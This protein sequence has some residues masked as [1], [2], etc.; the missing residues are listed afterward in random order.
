MKIN[1][2]N[3]TNLLSDFLEEKKYNFII[4]DNKRKELLYKSIYNIGISCIE[5][6]MENA[7][8]NVSNRLGW[9]L[10][11]SINNNDAPT[12]THCCKDAKYKGYQDKILEILI[13]EDYIRIKTAIELRTKENNMWDKLFDGQTQSLTQK[14]LKELNRRNITKNKL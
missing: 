11:E 7:L 14:F 10:I 6:N 5:N 4:S 13:K 2:I 1:V 9:F 3:V 8:R 12:L